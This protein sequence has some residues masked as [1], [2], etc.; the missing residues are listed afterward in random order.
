M[1]EVVKRNLPADVDAWFREIRDRGWAQ[2]DWFANVPEGAGVGLE[3][4]VSA[5]E[6]QEG[7]SEDDEAQNRFAIR[8]DLN[9]SADIDNENNSLMAGLGTMV[10]TSHI[11]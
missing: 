5:D 11:S 2:C 4:S 1:P 6:A 8:R 9:N 10:R 3:E 7:D